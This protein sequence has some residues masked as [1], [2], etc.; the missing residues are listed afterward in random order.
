MSRNKNQPS[1]ADQRTDYLPS[2]AEIRERCLEVQKQWTEKERL[3]RRLGN[4]MQY[5][6]SPEYNSITI[7]GTTIYYES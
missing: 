6:T 3:R 4:F 5:V 2:Q 1:Q 7:R